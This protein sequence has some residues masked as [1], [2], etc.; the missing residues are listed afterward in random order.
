MTVV[1]SLPWTSEDWRTRFRQS[2]SP[3]Y[4]GKANATYAPPDLLP[5]PPFPPPAAITT[6][7]RPLISKT[8]GVAL[9]ENGNVVSHN[10]SPVALSKTWNFLSKL[11]APMKTRPPAVTTGP[12]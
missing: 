7:W 1:L 5:R 4:R 6:N 9:P 12:P 3:D 11:V 10:S 2:W 8:A